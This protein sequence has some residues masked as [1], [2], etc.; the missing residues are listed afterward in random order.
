M[1]SISVVDKMKRSI[2]DV[3]VNSSDSF[4]SETPNKKKTANNKNNNNSS[5]IFDLPQ[6]IF[7]II[8]SDYGYKEAQ[9]YMNDLQKITTRFMIRHG[10]SIGISDLIIHPDIR[11]KNEDIIINTKK[12][13]V[14]IMKK[15]HLNIFENITI[16]LN[17]VFESKILSFI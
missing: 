8:F 10:Y 13:V 16:N 3:V 14:D 11:K 4:Y 1:N 12:E 7:H 2:F 5:R 6:Y 9:R 15:I 17:K